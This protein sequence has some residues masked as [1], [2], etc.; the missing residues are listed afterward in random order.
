MAVMTLVYILG[1]IIL[2]LVNVI[3]EHKHKKWLIA[4]GVLLAL[5]AIFTFTRVY[6]RLPS[7]NLLSILISN[8]FWGAIYEGIA[9]FF[10]PKHSER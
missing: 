7:R 3:Y 6:F 8:G 2:F 9:I 4:N 10:A 5:F 1:P